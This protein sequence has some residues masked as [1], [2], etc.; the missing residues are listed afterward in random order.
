MS[1]FKSKSQMRISFG[2]Y[3]GPTMKAK[4]K[5]WADETKNI[6]S[7]PNKKNSLPRMKNRMKK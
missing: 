6:K 2:G 4:A 1:P 5:T 3:L 7:L